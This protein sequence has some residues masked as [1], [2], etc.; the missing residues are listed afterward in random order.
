MGT[1]NA[2]HGA[3]IRLSDM[4]STPAYTDIDDI[5]SGPDGGGITPNIIKAFVHSQA[6]ELKR[7]TYVMF[8]P[9]TFTV[10]YDSTDAQHLA[11]VAG[12]KDRTLLDFHIIDVDAGA[13]QMAFSAY[14]G[15]NFSKN[16]DGWSEASFTL[17][18]Y[19]GVTFT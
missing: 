12:A 1:P 14:V 10:L 19:N 8:E 2:A 9:V 5:S 17:E 13:E 16:P 7:A 18:I 15:V 6:A 4:A 11:L 3:K